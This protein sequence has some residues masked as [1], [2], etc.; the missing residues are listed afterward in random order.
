METAISVQISWSYTFSVS[1]TQLSSDVDF[2][3]SDLKY[4]YYLY[5][6]DESDIIVNNK[7]TDFL[8]GGYGNF[9]DNLSV[10]INCINI[11]PKYRNKKIKV[12][13]LAYH[14]AYNLYDSVSF[15]IICI[16]KPSLTMKNQ[17]YSIPSYYSLRDS[18]SPIAYNKNIFVS[19]EGY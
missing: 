10:K 5:T 7:N 3:N 16:I 1:K 18:S 4:A 15:E 9:D 13:I 19:V 11:N 12:A 17:N 14:F 6:Y 8:C 2:A